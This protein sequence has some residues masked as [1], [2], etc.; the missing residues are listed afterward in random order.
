MIFRKL[1]LVAVL[2]AGSL[3]V[4]TASA[5]AAQAQAYNSVDAEFTRMMIPHHYQALV[6]GD[7]VPDRSSDARMRSLASRIHI[8]QGLEITSMR[9]W[10]GRN[11]LP[12]TDPEA[13]YQEL[14]GM[15]EMLERMGMATPADLERLA[16]LSGTEFDVLFLNLMITHH[17]GA[18]RM[19]REVLLHGSDVEL[20]QQAQDMMTTQRAQ[21]AIMKDM[22]AKAA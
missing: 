13:A 2:I 10:Q 18:V 4:A 1:S 22:L 6:M 11:D 16:G 17:E 5:G 3:G 20:H 9:G 21:I 7:L 14:L 15:P 19:L 12:R 8:E